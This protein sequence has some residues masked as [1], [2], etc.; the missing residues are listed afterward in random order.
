ML[1]ENYPAIARWQKIPAG[2]SINDAEYP[3]AV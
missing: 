2:S 1:I 3:A